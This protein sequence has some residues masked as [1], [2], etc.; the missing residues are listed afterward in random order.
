[1]TVAIE[2][3][4]VRGEGARWPRG[5]DRCGVARPG[6]AAGGHRRPSPS[7][8][9]AQAEVAEC[10]ERLLPG[11][12]GVVGLVHVDAGQAV[13]HGPVDGEVAVSYTHLRAHETRH[14]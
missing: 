1:M 8:R 11:R 14:D 13:D 5:S 4:C 6:W 9:S 12:R 3:S 10:L 7:T 2:L